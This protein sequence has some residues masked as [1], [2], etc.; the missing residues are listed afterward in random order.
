MCG[1]PWPSG[2]KGHPAAGLFRGEIS[3]RGG[4]RTG[5]VVAALGLSQT[6]AGQGLGAET[7]SEEAAAMTPVLTYRVILPEGAD[8]TKSLA[9]LRQLE[10]EEPQLHVEFDTHRQ[11]IRVGIM[12]RCSWRS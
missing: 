7:A 9:Q 8:L 10:E 3:D 1:I 12:G 2:R 6:Y 11:E 5:D 4:S